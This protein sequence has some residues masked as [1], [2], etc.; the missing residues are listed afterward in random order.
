MA[1]AS[2][3]EMMNIWRQ[4][5]S[6]RA[7]ETPDG[8]GSAGDS[9]SASQRDKEIVERCQKGDMAAFDEIVTLYRGKVYAM[10]LNMIHNDADAWDLSQ[11]VFVKAW[12]ALPKFEARSAFYTWLYRI[13]HN[14]TYDWIRKRKATVSG[15]FDDEVA[16]QAESGAPTAP[17]AAERPDQAME[18]GELRGRI[19]EAI[20][21]LSP[22]H[23]EVILRKEVDGL[24][25]QEIADSIGCSIG[26]VMS[27]LFYARKK[28]Q[29]ALEG[30]SQ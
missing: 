29:T 12:K 25:Y 30:E 24:S 16:Q 22:D 26:T 20:E 28:L 3:L 5:P 11:D 17:R 18:R 14:V 15:E 19:A 7:S 10:I 9:V 13:T 21:A 6:N 23:R 8:G 27:R 1:A 4:I 2:I